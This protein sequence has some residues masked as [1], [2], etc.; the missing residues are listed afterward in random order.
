MFLH[1]VI[2]NE[3]TFYYYYYIIPYCWLFADTAVHIIRNIHQ[4]FYSMLYFSP[5]F[6][7]NSLH[8]FVSENMKDCNTCEVSNDDNDVGAFK[9]Q[10][11][12]EVKSMKTSD[13]KGELAKS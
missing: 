9:A 6:K 11:H 3:C 5:L 13:L 2:V 4:N 8:Y 1:L 12:E 10:L 7:P